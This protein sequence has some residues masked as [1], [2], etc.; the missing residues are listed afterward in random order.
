[1]DTAVGQ[2]AALNRGLGCNALLR[3]DLDEWGLFSSEYACVVRGY[4]RGVIVI[5]R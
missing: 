2:G 5:W 1:M 3:I 4:G